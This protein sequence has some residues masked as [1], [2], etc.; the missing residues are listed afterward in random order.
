M[1]QKP[2]LANKSLGLVEFPYRV[3]ISIIFLS[4]STVGKNIVLGG[5]LEQDYS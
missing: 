1:N 3:M 2:N 5:W 4:N